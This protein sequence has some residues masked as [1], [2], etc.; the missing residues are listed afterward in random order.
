MKKLNIKSILFLFP[1]LLSITLVAQSEEA[2]TKE[3]YNAGRDTIVTDSMNIH[4]PRFEISGIQYKR[5]E[6]GV[7]SL[8]IR[9]GSLF[10]IGFNTF[11]HN[12]SAQLPNELDHLDLDLGKSIHFKWDIVRS[13][14]G[15]KDQTLG[16]EYGLA[17]S[18]I[19]YAFNNSTR[20]TP[21]TGTHQ[22]TSEDISYKKNKLKTSFLEIPVMLSIRS[23]SRS[24]FNLSAGGYA[25]LLLRT[26]QKFK[27]ENNVKEKVKDDFNI[28]KFRFGLQGIIGIGNAKVYAQYSLTDLFVENEGPELTPLNFGIV[29][30]GF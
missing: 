18:Y 25:G 11:L 21:N 4:E 7:Q 13:R 14:L 15:R 20:L 28:N 9:L 8:E 24:G 27:N 6:D 12:G 10:S 5:N 23:K 3:T 2:T 26:K 29:L 1:L 19:G 16:I 22:F 17:I 30:A